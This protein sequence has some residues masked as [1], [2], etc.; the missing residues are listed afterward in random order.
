MTTTAATESNTR[1]RFALKREAKQPPFFISHALITCQNLLHYI[2]VTK[3]QKTWV[4]SHGKQKLPSAQNAVSA[5][6]SALSL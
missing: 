6:R 4:L 2:G 5:G 1:N 3:A